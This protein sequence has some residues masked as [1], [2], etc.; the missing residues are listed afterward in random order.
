MN[1][2]NTKLSIILL[3]ILLSF[4]LSAQTVATVGI[5]A[6]S[7]C[8]FTQIQTAIDSGADEVRVLNNQIFDANLIIDSSIVLKGGYPNCAAAA[9]DQPNGITRH[10][11]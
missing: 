7:F 10:S 3:T 4:N 5:S 1:N 2:L 9:S 8:G 11:H 6:G